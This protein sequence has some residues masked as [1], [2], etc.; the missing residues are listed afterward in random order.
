MQ[1]F[2]NDYYGETIWQYVEY[3]KYFNRH[4]TRLD[5]QP[6]QTCG[7][8]ILFKA[9]TNTNFLRHIWNIPGNESNNQELTHTQQK[10]NQDSVKWRGPSIPSEN[11]SGLLVL[12]T[13]GDSNL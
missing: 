1:N 4:S 5:V 7:N 10:G 11:V 9:K 8:V 6:W 12:S 3:C 2:V 13:V